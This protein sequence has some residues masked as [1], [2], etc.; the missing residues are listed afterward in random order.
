MSPTWTVGVIF[1]TIFSH[2]FEGAHF[3]QNEFKK[4][5]RQAAA[6]PGERC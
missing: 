3:A 6:L 1:D 2:P 4:Q 5:T